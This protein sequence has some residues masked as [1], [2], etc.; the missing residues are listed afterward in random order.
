MNNPQLPQSNR[1]ALVLILIVSAFAGGLLIGSSGIMTRATQATASGDVP[2]DSSYISQIYDKMQSDYLGTVPAQDKITQSI[3]KGLID[4]LSDPYSA[5]LNPTDAQNYLKLADSAYDGIGVSLGY[6]GQY[7]TVETVMDGFPGQ[8]AGLKSGDLVVSVD[9]QDMT[10]VRPEVVSTKVKGVA[11]T[12]VKLTIFRESEAK[13][14]D[15]TIVRGEIKLDNITYNQ[16]PN[17]VVQIHI[18]RFTEGEKNGLS[19]VE[20][21]NNEWD[22]AVT[23]VAALNPKAIIM[24][25]RN[26]PGGFVDGVRHVA[27]EFFTDGTVMMREQQKGQD[28]I[29]YRDN[30]QGKFESV[31]LVVLVNEGSASAS[32]IFSGAVQDN[33]RGQIVGEKTVGKGVEQELLP[34]SD[35]SILLLVFRKWLTPNDRQ[36]TKDNPITP[37][38]IVSYTAA[39]TANGQDTQVAKALQIIAGQ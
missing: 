11:G 27:E 3:A 1:T 37:D 23:K 7:T 24:D 29:V 5:Y 22:A 39:T 19:G 15:F 13:N 4:S 2:F 21:F 33:K 25:L 35:N 38:A 30:R 10:N 12:S 34:M 6:N 14:L 28:E 20:V 36:I 31:P 16:L 9:G 8:T 17:G 18:G 26:N 32:E